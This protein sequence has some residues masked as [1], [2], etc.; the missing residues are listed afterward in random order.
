MLV[1]EDDD[2]ECSTDTC[3]C[4]DVRGGCSAYLSA[5]DDFSV[6]SWDADSRTTWLRVSARVGLLVVIIGRGRYPPTD[7]GAA[8]VGA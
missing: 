5:R 7:S 8:A 6:P 2:A 4:D 3:F 1:D